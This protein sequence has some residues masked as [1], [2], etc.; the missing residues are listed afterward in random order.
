MADMTFSCPLCQQPICCDELWS[1][2]EIKCPSCQ[3]NLTVPANSHS[4][5]TAADAD[6]P[7]V[8]KP[9]AGVKLTMSGAKAPPLHERALPIRNLAPP[10]PPKKNRLAQAAKIVVPLL[11]LGVGGY[12]GYGWYS[13]R[14]SKSAESAPAANPAQAQTGTGGQEPAP[15]TPPPPAPAVWTLD[16]ENAKIPD[17]PANGTISGAKFSAEGARVDQVGPAQV[18]R[19][20]QGPVASPDRDILIYLE[21][22]SADALAGQTL[23]ISKSTK[24]AGVLEVIKRWKASPQSA[25]EL[26]SFPN[27]YALKLEL[28][29]P[30][31]GVLPGKIFLA[32]PDA[33]QT[34]VAGLFKAQVSSAK[35]SAST[36]SRPAVPQKTAKIRTKPQQ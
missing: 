17:A 4:V 32:L 28:G 3:G 5:A 1:G 9:P 18:L 11:V 10:P 34:V 22:K 16:I 24:P 2:H 23:E 8:P 14:Q 25:L 35:A 6:N 26:K 15:A 13:G 19:L 29:Q 20:F 27:G 36:A 21:I 31:G 7:L 12:F 33:E 30:D